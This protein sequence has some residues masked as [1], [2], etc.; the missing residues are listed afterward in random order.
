MSQDI[1]DSWT[2]SAAAYSRLVHWPDRQ[3]HAVAVGL[4]RAP[5]AGEVPQQ[6]LVSTAPVAVKVGLS[7]RMV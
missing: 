5:A 7:S 4:G 2:H 6:P 3:Q 1:G